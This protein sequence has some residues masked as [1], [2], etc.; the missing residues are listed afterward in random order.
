[1]EVPCDNRMA[2]MVS[3]HACL[4]DMQKVCNPVLLKDI[5][6]GLL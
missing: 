4:G 5:T 1:M 6:K 3:V 2:A